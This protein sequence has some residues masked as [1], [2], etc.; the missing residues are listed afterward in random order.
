VA[1]EQPTVIDYR[2]PTRNE[3]PPPVPT[4]WDHHPTVPAVV[5]LAIALA[6]F[7]AVHFTRS[8]VHECAMC[9]LLLSPLWASWGIIRNLSR[10]AKPQVG[11]KVAA[12]TALFIYLVVAI[13][14]VLLG[15]HH[16]W[17]GPPDSY[18]FD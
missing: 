17:H 6:A 16:S 18:L 13:A 7:A 14:L 3:K 2:A 9:I 10:L 4:W 15:M 5:L 12:V 1:G 11:S 8:E